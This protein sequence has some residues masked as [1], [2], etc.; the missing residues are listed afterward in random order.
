MTNESIGKLV[1]RVGIGATMLFHGI[2]KATHGVGFIEG[3]LVA[4]GLPAFLAYGVYVGEIIAPL[5]LIVG[6]QTRIAGLIVAFNMFV[7]ILL[8][9]TKDIFTIT[10]HGA[11]GIE[12]PML[13]LVGG[14][15]VALIGAG[16]YSFD[17]KR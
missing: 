11:W 7:A 5:M 16:R 2:A 14:L 17:A 10:E 13:Y 6:F 12:L 3:M 8:V 1:L 9:H 15:A 4:K